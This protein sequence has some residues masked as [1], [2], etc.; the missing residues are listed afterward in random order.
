MNTFTTKWKTFDSHLITMN[1]SHQKSNSLTMEEVHKKYDSTRFTL[2]DYLFAS[3]MKYLCD[4]QVS[5]F[6]SI[7]NFIAFS[8]NLEK[9]F[10]GTTRLI[11]LG[12]LID[13]VL[14]MVF[15]PIEKINSAIA[16]IDK[17]LSSRTRKV[18]VNQIQKLTGFL[19]FLCKCVV[20]GRA[21]T[22]FMKYV[23]NQF[24]WLLYVT[25]K[26]APLCVNCIMSRFLWPPQ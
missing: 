23:F 7:C 2:D 24:W 15:V 22:M 8:V 9:T 19:N 12:L 1:V 4:A 25:S 10:W 14:Q 13:T 18:T 3:L 6:I 26:L 16:M 11:F 21:F 17:V 20:P 5:E